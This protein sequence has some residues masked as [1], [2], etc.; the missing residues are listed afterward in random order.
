MARVIASEN[1][2][3]DGVVEDPTGEEG[4]PGGGW[5]F[6][7]GPGD[8][9]A[10]GHA[11]LEEA[12][13]ADAFVMGRR[14]YEFL[15]S[16]WPTRTGALADRLNGIPKYVVSGRFQEP[17]WRNTT[18]LRGDVVTHVTTLKREIPGEIVIPASF[19]LV[20]S[21]FQHDL[22][23]ELRLIVYPLVLGSGRRLFEHISDSES[24]R[25]R[26]VGRIGD[27]L[28]TSS[29]EVTHRDQRP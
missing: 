15:A 9:E 1:V 28:V 19:T 3:V 17:A 29:Y 14:T 18:V 7:V 2:T 8:R 26:D 24:L 4:T 20:R 5:F 22:V 10:F 16:R 27:H 6:R 23:D 13:A 21:L 12:V 25:L 11:A